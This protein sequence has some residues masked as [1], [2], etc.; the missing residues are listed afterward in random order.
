[1][2]YSHIFY[3]VISIK[4]HALAYDFVTEESIY[5]QFINEFNRYSKE[6]NLDIDVKLIIVSPS[7]STTLIDDYGST[8]DILLQKKSEKYDI[9]FF[10]SIYIH[11][12]GSHFIDLSEWIPEK[13]INKFN[14]K[15]INQT[16][17]HN[18]KLVSFPISREYDVLYSNSELLK[19]Y[20]KRIPTTWDELYETCKYISEEEKKLNNTNLIIYEGLFPDN[21]LGTCSLHEFIYSFRNYTYSPFPELI[22]QESI[23]ALSMLK[24]IKNDVSSEYEMKANA[25]LF[26][27]NV[28]TG[29]ALF[30]KSW[31]FPFLV[32]NFYQV[33]VLPG[34]KEGVSGSIIGGYNVAINKYSNKKNIKAAV[35]ALE[36]IT[37][38]KFQKNFTLYYNITPI[39]PNLLNDEEICKQIDCELIKKIQPIERPTTKYNDYDYYSQKYREYIYEYLFEDVDINYA[40]KKVDDI[41]RIYYMTIKTT[42]TWVGF[43][44]L[45][46]SVVVEIIILFSLIVLFFEKFDSYFEFLSI[47][48]W[49]IS[50]IGLILFLSGNFIE[51]EGVT[52]YKCHLKLF[53]WSIGTTFNLIP[54]LHKLVSNFPIENK[55]TYSIKMHRY[56]FFIAFLLIDLLLNS[57]VLIK[58][59]VIKEK[60]IYEGENFNICKLDHIITKI[61]IITILLYKLLEFITILILNFIE[62]NIESTLGD[63]RQI[64]SM[65]YID[66]FFGILLEIFHVLDINNYKWRYTIEYF[67]CILIVVTN[68]IFMF[69]IKVLQGLIKNENIKL[70]Y[71]NKVNRKFINNETC[72]T[73]NFNNTEIINTNTINENI[74][75]TNID[76][77]SN[78]NS[79]ANPNPNTNTNINVNPSI[80]TNSSKSFFSKMMSC[81]Y[82]TSVVSSM[83]IIS[84]QY[85]TKL[86]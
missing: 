74:I 20:N 63:I 44:T 56:S 53:V 38:E 34:N 40:L 69:G 10:D 14:E 27:I 46:I 55:I 65:I 17:Y 28:F 47:D 66:I 25:D 86:L 62:W 16:C 51:F 50:M 83:E 5:G 48:F 12:F 58:P 23:N 33:S 45:I 9:I 6:Q 67:I 64:T 82:Q 19:K 31:Y 30:L 59:Y 42:N 35:K 70:T 81:H 32:N 26:Y 80:N 11:K 41:T 75:S 21:E 22:S 57:L 37:S 85:S 39:I 29:N 49:I 72:T 24:K 78:T 15:D 79:N 1:M 60:F 2:L 61:I 18:N 3:N 52:V 84:S 43:I 71:I 77:V 54:I 73:E 13:H 8:I 68:Y 76:I 7:N 36:Y 4:I